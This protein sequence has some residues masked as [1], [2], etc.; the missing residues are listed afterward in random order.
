MKKFLIT[1]LIAFTFTTCLSQTFNNQRLDSL[2]HLLEKNNK[3][4]GSIA[5]S[6]NGKLIYSNTIG[7][8]NLETAKKADNLT[9]YRIGSISKM[10]TASLIL[11]AVEEKKLSLNQ[12]LDKYFPQIE[13]SKKITIEHLL[14]HKTGIHDFTNNKNYLTY[15]TQPK[16]E[17]QI[18]EIIATD[19]SDFEPNSKI[20]YSN[21]NYIILSYILEKIY[22]QPYSKILET[23]IIKPLSL[24]N[25]YFGSSSQIQDNESRSYHFTNKWDK[26]TDTD[27][28]IPM[29]AGAII[30]N[31]TDL[32]IFIEQLFKGKLISHKSLTLMTT[33]TD[34]HGMGIGMGMLEFKNF[35][36][37]S[38]GHNGAIDDFQSVLCYF[39]QEKLTVALTSN[40]LSYP[41]ENVLSC[42]VSSNFNKPF[43][44]PSFKT[45]EVEPKIMD[46]YLGQYV[47]QQTQMKIAITK[48]EN[49]LSA[50]LAGQNA[51]PLE[52]NT[53]NSFKF[54]PAGIV[55]EFNSLKNEMTLKQG[56]K[57][58]LFIKE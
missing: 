32:T 45:I 35:E 9:K 2:F 41:I 3:F 10:F 14:N 38:Y 47:N 31:P 18:I 44:M 20:T 39:P 13:N 4:M 16:S 27:V 25:T 56:G 48:N 1:G 6:Q 58:F 55:L 29:G 34:F 36:Q 30:S 37:K 50:Q 49:K 57:E 33:T 53:V 12:T 51:F 15:N 7:Y 19:K 54:E 52:A 24:K 17:T 26:S 42:A 8:S 46:L 40:G 22:K 28:S 43:K 21:P 5:V 11:K 23:K